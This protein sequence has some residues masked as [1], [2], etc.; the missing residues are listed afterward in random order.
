MNAIAA[1][2]E[3]LDERY[4]G[5]HGFDPI[6]ASIWLSTY[7]FPL[8]LKTLEIYSRK[9]SA[10]S[11]AKF[12][13]AL[14]RVLLMP[15]VTANIERLAVGCEGTEIRVEQLQKVFGS[16]HFPKLRHLGL[17]YWFCPDPS[18]MADLLIRHRATLQRVYLVKVDAGKGMSSQK[19]RRDWNTVFLSL[20]GAS[21]PHLR[22]FDLTVPAWSAKSPDLMVSATAFI[23]RQQDGSPF[24]HDGPDER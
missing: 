14:R 2:L 20:R 19:C 21:F 5:S 7:P 17:Q 16:T 8:K 23:L 11:Y 13:N 12:C 1:G 3:H 9:T 18:Y 10:T 15:S 22:Q 24:N 6:T 4:H